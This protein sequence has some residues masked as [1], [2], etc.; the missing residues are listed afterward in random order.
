M[1]AAVQEAINAIDGARIAYRVH[2]PERPVGT[3]P[4]V[5]VHGTALSQAIWRG[6]G[7]TRTLSADR[8]VIT[9][10]LRGHGRS[11]HPHD[12]SAYT[13]PLFAAD[14]LAVLD[15]CDVDR[16]HVAG[17]SL[18]GRIGFHL[19]QSAPER[20][21]SLLSIAGAP[22]NVRG[23]FDRVFFPGVIDALETG[24]IEVL[25]ERWSAHI[26]RPVPAAT[27]DAFRADDALALAAYMRAADVD[28]GV[29]LH[30][31]SG[32]TRPV[33][34]LVGARDRERLHAAELAAAHLPDARLVVVPD[35]THGDVVW[36]R[37]SLE[38]VQRFLTDIDAP[39]AID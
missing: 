10:D 9:L 28:G 2:S 14:V 3:H 38:A 6:A 5:L 34:L 30:S 39:T 7:W 31:L 18:G 33:L 19:T 8:T 25:L 17:Y 36:R 12:Q 21:A 23:A 11:A 35:A 20:M 16:A 4:L 24:D 37:A 32:F 22:K 13:M 27:A 29:S 26:G 15:A 1:S